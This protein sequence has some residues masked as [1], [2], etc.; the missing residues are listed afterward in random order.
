M[1]TTTIVLLLNLGSLVAVFITV[2]LLFRQNRNTHDW[3]RRQAAHDLNSEAALGRGYALR[4]QLELKINIYDPDETYS[5]VEGNLGD[6][7]RRLLDTILNFFENVCIAIKNHVVEEKIVFDSLS[8]VMLAY[9]RWADPY[10]KDN[11]A[12]INDRLWQ[13]IDV[14]MPRWQERWEE[15]DRQDEKTKRQR[16]ANALRKGLPRLK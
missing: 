14:F 16:A 15:L 13:E 6:E 5:A 1:D 11:R 2:F 8:S 12:N 7:D 9:W 3:N 4:A 10:I